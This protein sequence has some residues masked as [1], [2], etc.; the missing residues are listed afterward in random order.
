MVAVISLPA[1]A[2]NVDPNA[3]GRFESHPLWPVRLAFAAFL[4]GNAT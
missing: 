4:K 2:G 1:R 3:L